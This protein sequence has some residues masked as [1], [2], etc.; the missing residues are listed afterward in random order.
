VELGELSV[1]TLL[2]H[3]R[4]ETACRY[5]GDAMLQRS[6]PGRSALYDIDLEIGPSRGIRI[7]ISILQKKID[8]NGR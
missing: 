6:G 5:W 8:L 2:T 4:D 7:F 3:D 1:C